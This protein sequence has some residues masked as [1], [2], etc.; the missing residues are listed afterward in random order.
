MG[1][2]KTVSHL[3][4]AAAELLFKQPTELPPDLTAL[5]IKFNA[6]AEAL[7]RTVRMS[8]QSFG[9]Q[10][11]KDAQI[12]FGES[13]INYGAEV[14]W[15]AAHAAHAAQIWVPPLTRKTHAFQ[16]WRPGSS[17]LVRSRS[18]TRSSRRASYR[19]G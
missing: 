3:R 11:T 8:K 6:R 7:E 2:S 5:E 17:L 19:S 4:E 1:V 14:W 18:R 10:S 13:L 16:T 12:R 15:A 9:F